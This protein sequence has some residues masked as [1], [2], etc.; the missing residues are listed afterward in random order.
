MSQTNVIKV[1]KNGSMTADEIAKLLNI[2]KQHVLNIAKKLRLK[3]HVSNDGFKYR[4]SGEFWL[5]KFTLTD[6][7]KWEHLEPYQKI[8]GEKTM[9]QEAVIR[10]LQNGPLTSYQIE[11]LTGIPRLSI[12]AC[13]TKMRYKK[14]LK[15]EKVKMG[16]SWVSRYTL[17]PHMIEAEKVEEPRDLLTPFDIR[18]A[19]GIFSKAEYASMN[20]Q[21]IRLFGRPKTNE[22]TNNQFI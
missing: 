10:A 17:E 5:T 11:D 12:A 6:E 9:T 4:E 1:L 20:N 13:C 3:G 19:K 18:N 15:I 14:K 16:R 8:K 21:A 22:I 7:S 2:P